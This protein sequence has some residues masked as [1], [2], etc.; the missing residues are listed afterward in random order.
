MKTSTELID[1]IHEMYAQTLIPDE[2]ESEPTRKD[3]DDDD[4]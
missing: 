2:L 4:Q 1:W 3:R